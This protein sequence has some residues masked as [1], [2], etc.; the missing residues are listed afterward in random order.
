MCSGRLVKAGHLLRAGRGPGRAAL[1]TFQK[2]GHHSTP[3]QR[4]AFLRTHESLP[5][6]PTQRTGRAWDAG[7]QGTRVA[8]ERARGTER[9]LL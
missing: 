1:W 8:R 6:A 9:A 5:W 2:S 7:S 3:G 4:N